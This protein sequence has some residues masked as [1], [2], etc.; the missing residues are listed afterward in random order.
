MDHSGSRGGGGGEG[1]T[2]DMWHTHVR[3]DTGIAIILCVYLAS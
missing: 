3:R 2:E 1:A